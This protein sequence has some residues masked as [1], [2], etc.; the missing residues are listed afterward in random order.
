MPKEKEF[1]AYGD[2]L[3]TGYLLG[4]VR[5]VD[6]VNQIPG[7]NIRAQHDPKYPD[8]SGNIC[9]GCNCAIA[10]DGS[11]MCNNPEW[12]HKTGQPIDPND[13]TQILEV[14]EIDLDD[15]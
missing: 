7:V 12:D 9:N 6:D 1:D 4:V 14:P 3:Q 11:C 8:K 10:Q 5:K 13:R 2:A 15:N